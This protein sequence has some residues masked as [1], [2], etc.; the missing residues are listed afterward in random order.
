MQSLFKHTTTLFRNSSQQ[1]TRLTAT[2]EMNKT[3]IMTKY[4][5]KSKG[6]VKKRWR[7]QASGNIKTWPSNKL[8]NSSIYR[9]TGIPNTHQLLKPLMTPFN[10]STPAER[11]KKHEEL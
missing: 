8:G 5:L 2:V 10:G 1:T 9:V 3:Q 11:A 4:K 7:L 6:A